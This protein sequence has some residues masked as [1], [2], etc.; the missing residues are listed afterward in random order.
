MASSSRPFSR[1]MRAMAFQMKTSGNCVSR[2]LA[3]YSARY[4]RSDSSA[5]STWP[6]YRWLNVTPKRMAKGTEALVHARVVHALDEPA[7]SIGGALR[8]LLRLQVFLLGVG[9]CGLYRRKIVLAHRKIRV[10]GD[11]LLRQLEVLGPDLEVLD[12]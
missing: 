12:A 10:G 4:V 1:L 8:H 11:E 7:L 3:L 5:A 6:S 9:G 2:R